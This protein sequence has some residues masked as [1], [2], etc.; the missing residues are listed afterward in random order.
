MKY[1]VPHPLTFWLLYLLPLL[2]LLAPSYLGSEHTNTSEIVASAGCVLVQLW[3]IYR[4]MKF[5][6]AKG[7]IAVVRRDFKIVKLL[8]IF[9]TLLMLYAVMHE[10][11]LKPYLTDPLVGY[12]MGTDTLVFGALL[13]LSLLTICWVAARTVCDLLPSSRSP[14]AFVEFVLFVAL[15][16]GCP[17][18]YAQT[19]RVVNSGILGTQYLIRFRI[20]YYP[21]NAPV[22]SGWRRA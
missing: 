10:V 3:W 4:A 1:T 11:M 7:A 18:I 2:V 5:L 15:V 21:Y 12:V 6:N 20:K 9:V 14:S 16:I 8:S 19:K 22:A 17:F 13:T